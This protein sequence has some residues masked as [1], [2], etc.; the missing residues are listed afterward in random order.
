MPPRRRLYPLAVAPSTTHHENHRNKQH[1]LGHRR[2]SKS[3][4]R[5]EPRRRRRRS[6][7]ELFSGR[8]HLAASPTR[9]SRERVS[10]EGKRNMRD[11]GSDPAVEDRGEERRPQCIDQGRGT[12]HPRSTCG[13]PR[14]SPCRKR[15]QERSGDQE[16]AKRDPKAP[17]QC[18]KR[19]HEPREGPVNSWRTETRRRTSPSKRAT[20]PRWSSALCFRVRAR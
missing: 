13:V 3:E 9:G 5:R 1:G 6:S 8:H 4:R 12:T 14:G 11:D 19:R 20:T 17:W 18:R 7:R 16:N 10:G 2:H 15:S